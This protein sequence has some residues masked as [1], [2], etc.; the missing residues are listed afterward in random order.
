MM[1]VILTRLAAEESIGIVFR[2]DPDLHHWD[3]NRTV[4]EELAARLGIAEPL[5]TFSDFPIGTMFWART[6]ALKPL[7]DLKLGWK[8]YPR[9]PIPSDGTI[10]HAIER[11]LPFIARQAGYRFVTTH[12]PGIRR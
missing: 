12:V 6:A 8:E 3:D 5:P 7:L 9:E 1:D 11:L 10:L 4:A 2:E